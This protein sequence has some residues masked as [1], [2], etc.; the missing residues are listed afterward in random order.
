M[1]PTASC[2]LL[3]ALDVAVEIRFRL[4]IRK[5][6]FPERNRLS[7]SSHPWKCSINVWMLHWGQG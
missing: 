6:L 4:E 7:G 1:H 5:Y 3:L 2:S